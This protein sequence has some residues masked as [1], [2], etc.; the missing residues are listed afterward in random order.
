MLHTHSK[1]VSGYFLSCGINVGNVR[2]QE[3][4]ETVA[5]LVAVNGDVVWVTQV[6]QWAVA[7]GA[8]VVC[9]AGALVASVQ[10]ASCLVSAE[11]WWCCCGVGGGLV[12]AFA[13]CYDLLKQSY[14]PFDWVV[15]VVVWAPFD[16]CGPKLE[17]IGGAA[18]V[19][20]AEVVRGEQCWKSPV[21]VCQVVDVVVDQQ[22]GCAGAGG[23]FRWKVE[24][25]YGEDAVVD[26]GLFIAVVKKCL[27]FW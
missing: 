22:G 4:V 14:G 27:Q 23:A 13:F 11:R 6:A 5:S 19:C 3:V 10:Q 26:E 21:A 12:E 1:P 9:D 15:V 8:A 18:Q 24:K 17:Q 16:G 25:F 2:G 20:G 7:K